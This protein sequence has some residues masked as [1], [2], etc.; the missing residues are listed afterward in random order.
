MNQI[1]SR[2]LV[3]SLV[4]SL[5]LG[6]SVAIAQV[7]P[8]TVGA[9]PTTVA[10]PAMATAPFTIAAAGEYQI[11][12]IAAGLD[13]QLMVVQGDAVV[14]EDS[15]SGDGVDARVVAFLAPGSYG[16]RVWEYRGR[17]MGVRLRVQRLA[18]L[19]SAATITPGAP[20]AIVNVAAGASPRESSVE[21]TLTIATAGTYRIDAVSPGAAIDP[22]LMIIQNGAQLATDSDSGEGTSAQIVRAHTP[23][24]YT[25]RVRDWVSRAGAISIT[26]VP[27]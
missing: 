6:A 27:Q 21:V 8:L 15:D 11:D 13:A 12:A 23:G 19:A 9:P 10:V 20:P 22:E 17:A 2:F 26:V 1:R 18:P 3:S 14:F 5:A 4:L 25:L 7:A 24:T 16:A